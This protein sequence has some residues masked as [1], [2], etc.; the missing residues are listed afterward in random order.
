MENDE[1]IITIADT[2]VDGVAINRFYGSKKK[3]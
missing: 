1:W 3:K 2:S